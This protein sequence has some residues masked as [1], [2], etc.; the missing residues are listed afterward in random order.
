MHIEEMAEKSSV[1]A[2]R[3]CPEENG[4]CK[5][6]L[7]MSLFIVI[8]CLE[9]PQLLLSFILEKTICTPNNHCT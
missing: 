4:F 5:D 9:L 2:F 8:I 3:V 7:G 6:G 1:V